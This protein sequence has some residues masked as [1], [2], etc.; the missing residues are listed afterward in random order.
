M[1]KTGTKPSKYDPNRHPRIA[2]ALALDGYI[3][4][5][6]A[7][8][9]G[10]S[11]RTLHYWKKRYPEFAD[12]LQKGKDVVDEGVE[13]ALLKRAMGYE[14]EET[15]VIADKSGKA[16]RVKRTKKQ[17][18]PDVIAQIFWLKN[19]KPTKWRDKHDIEHGGE[20]AVQIVD[21]IK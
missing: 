1:T 20:I 4:R 6:M 12:A 15:E 8:V 10:I 16:S 3:D 7:P 14:V 13:S 18:A 21:D 9:M 19:R 5:D 17:I 11:V 2:K